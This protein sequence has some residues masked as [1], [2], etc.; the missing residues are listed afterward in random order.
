MASGDSA[1]PARIAAEIAPQL[2]RVRL[3]VSGFMRTKTE[4][5]SK[6]YDV[7][8]PALLVLGM[9]RHTLPGRVVAVDDVLEL[10]VY[11]P[12][13]QTRAGIDALVTSGAVESAR[14][15]ALAVTDF[16]R[17]ILH[18]FFGL[19]REFID[20]LW[21]GHAER[22][23]ALLPIAEQA[24][25]AVSET[26]GAAARIM[27]PPYDPPDASPALRLAERLSVLRFHRFDAHAEAWRDEGL[28][29][30]QV[31]ALEPGE[32]R[33]RIEAE[34]NRR[35]AAPYAVLE[36]QQRLDLLGGLQQLPS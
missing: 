19:S 8:A 15:H 30:E 29:A 25:A 1:E 28:S 16:G 4:E 33:D 14:G 34:T 2:D 35:A 23:A 3:A 31:Q 13:E 22:V 11:A 18:T 24:A 17:E 9:L 36:P 12:S 21:A 6:R 20:A 27:T 7:P 26:G 10:F 5:V 32:Q